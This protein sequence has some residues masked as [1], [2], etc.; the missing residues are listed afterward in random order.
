MALPRKPRA[1]FSTNLP[2][3]GEKVQFH[4]M[5]REDEKILLMA[6]QSAAKMPRE[7]QMLEIM[8]AIKQLVEACMADPTPLSL[9][10]LEWMFIQIRM[11]S[12]DSQVPVS[13]HD[14]DDD[15]D[16]NFKVDLNAVKINKPECNPVIDLGDGLVIAMKHPPAALYEDPDFMKLTGAEM[17]DHLIVECMDKVFD[18]ENMTSIDTVPR[19]EVVE[20][21]NSLD[22]NSFQK[23]TEFFDNLPSME[24]K[25]TYKNTKGK[26]R[27][28]I[29]STLTDFFTFV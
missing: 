18:K 6:K 27:E 8:P 15:M 20:F 4:P 2:S 19:E 7:D 25:I 24:Y 3:T 21:I 10:D 16:Y 17:L 26:E 23:I 14:S 9:I 11:V 12:V 28:I 29:L 22:R 5:R 1:V 13:Y